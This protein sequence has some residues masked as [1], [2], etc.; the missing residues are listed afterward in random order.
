MERI[1]LTINGRAIEAEA[2]KTILQVAWDNDIHIPALCFH[3]HLLP[4]G[5]CRLCIVEVEGYANPV[6]SCVTTAIDGLSI[7]TH[8]ERLFKMRQD[9]VI[10]GRI[11]SISCNLE[12]GSKP[13]SLSLSINW[14]LFRNSSFERE[15]LTRSKSGCPMKLT[16]TPASL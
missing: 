1:R 3:E 9:F 11:F 4:I 12:P 8:S 10:T 13:I 16:L 7:T 14:T 5:A 6:A 2:G 15:G